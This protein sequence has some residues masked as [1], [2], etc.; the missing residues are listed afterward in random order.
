[1]KKTVESSLS[2]IIQNS[3]SS[4]RIRDKSDNETVLLLVARHGSLI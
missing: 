3:E 4:A 2:F 1:M